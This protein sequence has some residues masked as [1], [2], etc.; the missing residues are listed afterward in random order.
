[1]VRASVRPCDR[2][3]R[4]MT[5]R[6]LALFDDL[7]EAPSVRGIVCSRRHPLH[8]VWAAMIARCYSRGHDSF[9]RYGGRGIV[10][11]LEFRDFR[12]FVKWAISAGWR[13]GLQLDRIDNDG[14]Y[15]A[16]NC[17]IVTR[18]ENQL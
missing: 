3:E 8:G 13:H 14:P 5:N 6:Q 12:A 7:P 9:P 18:S 16:A 4:M 17:R 1:M 11:A 2:K 10:V 15:C